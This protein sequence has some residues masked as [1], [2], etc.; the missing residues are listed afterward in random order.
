VAT[1]RE[2]VPNTEFLTLDIYL[3]A[4]FRMSDVPVTTRM[5]VTKVVFVVDKTDAMFDVVQGRYRKNEP[6]PVMAFVQEIKSMRSRMNEERFK[7]QQK[8]QDMQ[9]R[10]DDT[11]LRIELEARQGGKEK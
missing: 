7:T 1:D 9:R 2:A 5:D 8:V 11:R 10:L 3:A 4:Y 6:V